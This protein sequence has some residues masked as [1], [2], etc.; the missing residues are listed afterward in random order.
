MH[1]FLKSAFA[2][3]CLRLEGFNFFYIPVPR[4]LVIRRGGAEEVCGKRSSFCNSKCSRVFSQVARH[5]NILSV[6]F[7]T[8]LVFVEV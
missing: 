3:V 4:E 6:N 5:K 8:Q 7:V 1:N 2:S